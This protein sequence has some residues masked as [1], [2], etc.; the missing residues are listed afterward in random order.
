MRRLGQ[1]DNAVTVGGEPLKPEQQAA[2]TALWDVIGELDNV[3]GVIV[4]VTP[5]HWSQMLTWSG[6]PVRRMA[7]TKPSVMIVPYGDES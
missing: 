7:V 5:R 6:Y 1:D 4:V 2:L 3:P